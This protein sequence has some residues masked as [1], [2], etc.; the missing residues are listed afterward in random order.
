MNEVKVESL[1][2]QHCQ[3][4]PQVNVTN[5]VKTQEKYVVNFAEDDRIFQPSSTLDSTLGLD[6]LKKK[7]PASYPSIQIG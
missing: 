4:Q 3:Q 2:Y 7:K 1:V 5:A 6:L